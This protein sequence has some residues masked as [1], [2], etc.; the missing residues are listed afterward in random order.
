MTK[1]VFKRTSFVQHEINRCF[2]SSRLHNAFL[3]EVSD[4]FLKYIISRVVFD[5][6]VPWGKRVRVFRVFCDASV[7]TKK[8]IAVGAYLILSSKEIESLTNVHQIQLEVEKKLTYVTLATSKPNVAEITTFIYMLKAFDKLRKIDSVINCYTDCQTL[9]DLLGE[10][11][12]K[13]V[14]NGF[15]NKKGKL[16]SH[17]QLYKDLFSIC[18]QYY[19]NIH[20]VKGHQANQDKKT[21]IDKIFSYVDRFSRK[22]LRSL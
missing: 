5:S 16:L 15:S 6:Q 17:Q 11:R 14:A 7:L 9:V 2:L 21:T 18:D 4:H 13:L 22:K 20:K 3:S 12:A 8:N 10:R 19:L 1:V